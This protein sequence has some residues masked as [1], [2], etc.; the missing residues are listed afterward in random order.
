MIEESSQRHLLSVLQQPL[1]RPLHEQKITGALANVV[2]PHVFD[3]FGI[4][5]VVVKQLV[6]PCGLQIL[7]QLTA[8]KD[9]LDLSGECW[10]LSPEVGIRFSGF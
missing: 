4:G 3:L 10:N 8:L 1:L 5:L 7:H 2:L 6:L 9:R